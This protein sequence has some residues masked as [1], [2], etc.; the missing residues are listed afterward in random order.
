MEFNTGFN[1]GFNI[2]TSSDSYKVS[3]AAQY[4]PGT[5]FVGSYFTGSDS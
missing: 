5:E 3:H 2:C 4:P 1:V